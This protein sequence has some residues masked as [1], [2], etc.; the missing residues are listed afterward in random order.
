MRKAI[1]SQRIQILYQNAFE[2]LLAVLLVSTVVVVV[3]WN[4]TAHETLIF[5]L[6]A[7]YA[8]SIA[9]LF[10]WRKFLHLHSTDYHVLLKWR[11]IFV[12][13]TFIS[14]CLWGYLAWGVSDFTSVFI[15]F[16]VFST[17]LAMAAGAMGAY[18]IYP[19]AYYAYIFP[20][21]TSMEM[22]LIYEGGDYIYTGALLGIFWIA[23][24]VI[25]KK[26]CHLYIESI[27][28]RFENDG[29]LHD[30]A[31]KK[32]EAEK[33]NA[34]KTKFLASASHDLRQ[35]MH[36]MNL[37][38]EGLAHE[39]NTDK[40]HELLDK[41]QHSMIDMSG[42]LNALLDMSKLDAGLV[43]T[44]IQAVD[45]S[46]LL[47]DLQD[48]FTTL[49]AAKGIA[50]F[51]E[52]K[53]PCFVMSDKVL[54][55][56]I[57]RNLISNAIKYTAHGHVQITYDIEKHQCI[58]KVQDTGIGIDTQHLKDVFQPFFQAH[59]PERDRARGLGL[60]LSIVSRLCALL[61]HK[62]LLDS[63]L[64][65]GSTFTLILPLADKAKQ[66]EPPKPRV[67]AEQ[68]QANILVI[69]DDEA[70]LDGMRVMLEQWGC[71]V[72]T[73][74]CIADL[75]QVLSSKPSIDLVIADY[76]LPNHERGTDAIE[77]AKTILGKP[78]LLG[79]IIS[80]DTEEKRMQQAQDSGFIMLH[81][82]VRPAQI[83]SLIQR[84]LIKHEG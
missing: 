74:T 12:I 29:L 80:G 47:H 53:Q 60:G 52:Y 70:I 65:Q 1:E 6:L 26:S 54:L 31:A 23:F 5:W 9:R 48:E 79:V 73:A 56:T 84:L 33:A 24:I 11:Q 68:L 13:G 57:L 3:L 72:F 32:E 2:P 37:F 67:L 42:L 38:A 51:V 77:R 82:P 40:Q 10:L 76:R 4:S 15:T 35:P 28:R 18:A 8:I 27:K 78:T 17:L 14:G 34:D 25:T 22:R 44:H 20:M 49:A 75:E 36:A 83:R 62:C 63:I 45:L 7:T 66:V 43:Q 21:M 55:S 19:P 46:A 81:K 69:D 50:L 30:L 61:K 58:L 16:S 41:L 59:N 71:T 64:G 39:L